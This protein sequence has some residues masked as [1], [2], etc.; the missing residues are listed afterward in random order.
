MTIT[1]MIFII[2]IVIWTINLGLVVKSEEKDLGYCKI[3]YVLLYACFL[4]TII[5]NYFI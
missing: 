2:G 5:E 4:L 3:M 1:K